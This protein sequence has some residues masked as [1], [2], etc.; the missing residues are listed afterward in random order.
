M[1]A[2]LSVCS[3]KR[4]SLKKPSRSKHRFPLLQTYLN[5]KITKLTEAAKVINFDFVSQQYITS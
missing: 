2:L 4:I 5:K 1:Y 3:Q